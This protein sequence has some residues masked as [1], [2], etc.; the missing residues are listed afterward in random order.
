MALV[1]LGFGERDGEQVCGLAGHRGGGQGLQVADGDFDEPAERF[2]GI[3]QAGLDV[4]GDVGFVGV[5]AGH[6]DNDLRGSVVQMLIEG[7]RAPI[8]CQVTVGHDGDLQSGELC[9]QRWRKFA[10]PWALVVASTPR[11]VRV[12]ASFP[13]R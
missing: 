3:P 12:S 13:L 5:E 6:Q 2:I 8:A 9:Q 4:I 7:R 10:A 1:G 11:P